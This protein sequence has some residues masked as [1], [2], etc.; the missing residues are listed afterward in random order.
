M[1]TAADLARAS[2]RLLVLKGVAAAASV[3]TGALARAVSA[4]RS[5]TLWW[6]GPQGDDLRAALDQVAGDARAVLPAWDSL[7][8]SISGLHGTATTLAAELAALERQRDA[9][10]STLSRL[11]RAARST[12]EEAFGVDAGIAAEETALARVEQ[13]IAEVARR[14]SLACQSAAPAIDGAVAAVSAG[15]RPP[16]TIRLGGLTLPAGPALASLVALLEGGPSTGADPAAVAEWWES[17]SRSERRTWL[18]LAPHVVGNLDGVPFAVR[19]VANRTAIQAL[20]DS[21]P[22]GDPLLE[23]LEQFLLP[24]TRLVDPERQIVVFDP[25]GDG[26]VAELFGDLASA[27]HLAVVVPGMG[28]TMSNF[29]SGLSHEAEALWAATPGSAVIAWTG[30]DAPAGA[31]TGRIWEVA[32]RAQGAA[33]GAALVPFLGALRHDRPVPTT[34]IGHSYGSF[35][36]GQSLLQGAQVDRVVFI[37]SPGVGVDHVSEFPAG[38]AREFFAGEVKGDPVATLERFGDAPTDPDFGAFAYDAGR[39]DS[40][41][42]IG[43]HSE[44]FDRGTAIDNLSAIVSGDAPTPDG[45]GLIER[46]LEWSEDVHDFAH[47]AVDRVQDATPLPPVVGP[48]IHGTIDTVQRADQAVTQVVNVIGETAGHYATE[49]A[50][51]TLDRG[52]DVVSGAR[53]VVDS[54]V[55]TITFWR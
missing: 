33:G 22:E 49:A 47:G 30:Y 12:V 44:Y 51:W 4:H 19:A 24:G 29:S 42:P 18:Q 55:D 17:L 32:S 40:F 27:T 53:D 52:I 54:A 35:T 34:L 15:T 5:S 21:L 11:W 1:V 39:P 8:S 37:G 10:H 14:W 28:S 48:V 45:P 50:G 13:A 7:E 9:A 23:R 6:T 25:T 38:A 16:G 43:R 31:E 20:V 46:G 41:N 36:V 3:D 26:R 2:T